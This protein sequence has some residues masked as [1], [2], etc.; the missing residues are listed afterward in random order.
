ML[1]MRIELVPF[2]REEE[3]AT[4]ATMLVSNVGGGMHTG[5]YAVEFTSDK[6]GK[7]TCVIRAFPRTRLHAVHLVAR[8]LKQ[9]GY[10]E[11]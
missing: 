5:S 11:P 4:L 2:G 1:R 6:D 8:A 3:K 7:L 10:V 9:L